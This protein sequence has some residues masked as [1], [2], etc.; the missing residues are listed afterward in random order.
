VTFNLGL[1]HLLQ[2]AESV[3]LVVEGR[4]NDPGAVCVAQ[5]ANTKLLD[6]EIYYEREVWVPLV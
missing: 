6:I 3:L 1:R 4:S 5:L 2:G